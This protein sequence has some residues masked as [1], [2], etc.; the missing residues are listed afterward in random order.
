MPPIHRLLAAAALAV[1]AVAPAAAAPPCHAPWGNERALESPCFSPVYASGDVSVRQYAPRGA[2]YAQAFLETSA[3]TDGDPAA[4]E[5][6]ILTAVFD[7]LLY[8]GGENAAGVP[9]AR[10]SPIFGR[11]NATRNSFFDWM[12]PTTVYPKPARAPAPPPGYKLAVVPSTLGAQGLVAAL[13]FTVTG[14]PAPGDFDA[15][16]ETLLPLLPALGYAPIEGPWS[17]TYAYYTSRDFPGQHDGECLVEVR[18]V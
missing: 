13:H 8:F 12:V 14:V 16:C 7:M 11:P 2:G 15:A 5:R 1:S 4:Y 18:K 6:D 9:V 10:T 3:P 17:P